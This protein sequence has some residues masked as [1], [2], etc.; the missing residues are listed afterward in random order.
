MLQCCWL[1]KKKWRQIQGKQLFSAVQGRRGRGA[2]PGEPKVSL[3][4]FHPHHTAHGRSPH[5]APVPWDCSPGSVSLELSENN[6]G[7][8]SQPSVYSLNIPSKNQ[9]TV[10]VMRC[11][12]IPPLLSIKEHCSV[13]TLGKRNF[14]TIFACRT[15][16]QILILFLRLKIIKTK[17]SSSSSFPL[18]PLSA[19]KNSQLCSCVLEATPFLPASCKCLYWCRKVTSRE[20][21]TIHPLRQP[22]VHCFSK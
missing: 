21:T 4:S 17:K 19:D 11:S 7:H 8:P 18:Y 15:H 1:P 14:W 22:D 2:G 5:S 9:D 10:E 16:S 6:K 3:W 13:I 12:W 20:K